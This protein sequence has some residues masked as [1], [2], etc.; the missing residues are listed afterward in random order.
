MDES[1]QQVTLVEYLGAAS[2]D[3]EREEDM[4]QNPSL[5]NFHVFTF[6]KIY[7]LNST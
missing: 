7:N 1:E 6:D 3:F 4:A 5:A 2:N